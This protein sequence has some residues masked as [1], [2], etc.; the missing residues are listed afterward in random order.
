MSEFKEFEAK[1]IDDA[2]NAACVAFQTE[3]D[4][5]EVEIIQDSKGGIFGLVGVKKAQI[6]ARLRDANAELKQIV[7]GVVERLVNTIVDDPR[8]EVEIEDKDRVKV[9]ILGDE[10]SGLLIGR[11]GQ[12]LAS[13]QYLANRIMAKKSTEPLRIQVDTG[14]YRERQDDSLRQL[15]LHLAD[16]AK[17]LG[18]VQST[19]PL[20]SYHRRVVHMTLQT[21]ETI[22]T[23]SKGDGPL[24]RVLI[25]PKRTRPQL[26]YEP[27]QQ[28]G[29]SLGRREQRVSNE[30]NGNRAPYV[31]HDE[32]GDE[33]Y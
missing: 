21:D 19:K 12:T 4:K 11:E 5:L 24:K 20:S 9:T 8:I 26:P 16:K 2:I 6:K 28:E 7:L 27:G 1:T 32:F 18:R 3:R 10:H 22:S 14:D 31:K 29:E 33:P 17:S 15:A 30:P 25:L 13:I 23:K